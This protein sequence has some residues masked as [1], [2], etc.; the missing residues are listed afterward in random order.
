MPPVDRD[1]RIWAGSWFALLLKRNQKVRRRLLRFEW[2]HPDRDPPPAVRC[3]PN[4]ISNVNGPL[5]RQSAVDRCPHRRADEFAGE[6]AELARRLAA[7]LIEVTFGV[8]VEIND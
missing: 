2:S 1:R 3:F 8:T 6:Q 7:G 4:A 5:L